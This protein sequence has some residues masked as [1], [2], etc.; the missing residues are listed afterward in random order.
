MDSSRQQTADS[1]Q[2]TADSRQQTADSRQQTADSRQQ[3]ADSRQQTADSRTLLR[4]IRRMVYRTDEQGRGQ[5]AERSA[6][7]NDEG[8]NSR[9]CWRVTVME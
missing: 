4:G 3:T 5:R 9:T 1:R 2:Q 7:P 8:V 6:G